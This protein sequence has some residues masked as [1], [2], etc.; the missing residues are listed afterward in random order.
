M[1]EIK[2]HDDLNMGEE[3]DRNWDEI[4]DETYNFQRLND[5][6]IYC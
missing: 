1:V 6:V 2:Q 3:F 4:V 5:E